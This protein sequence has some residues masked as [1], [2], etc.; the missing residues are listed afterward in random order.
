LERNHQGLDNELIEKLTGRPNLDA[1]VECCA[2]HA[3]VNT[4]SAPT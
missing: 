1:P 2:F 4:H 3:I